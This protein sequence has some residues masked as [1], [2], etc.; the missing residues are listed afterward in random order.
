VQK[1]NDTLAK[2]ERKCRVIIPMLI[3]LLM[4]NLVS[5]QESVCTLQYAAYSGETVADVPNSAGSLFLGMDGSAVD[6]L[7]EA[8]ILDAAI[9][10]FAP[11]G[12]WF[13]AL[14]NPAGADSTYWGTGDARFLDPNPGTPSVFD[15]LLHT[16]FSETGIDSV[17][18]SWDGGC[19]DPPGVTTISMTQCDSTRLWVPDM[20]EETS[21]GFE[22]GSSP[23]WDD[24]LICLRVG[25]TD[26]LVAS[27]TVFLEGAYSGGQM[28]VGTF[29]SNVP[30]SQPYDSS[31]YDATVLDFDSTITVTELPDGSV[32]WMLVSLRTGPGYAAEVSGSE[33]AVIVLQDGRLVEPNGSRLRFPGIVTSGYY[34]VARHRNHISVMSSDTVDTGDGLGSWDFTSA[35]SQAY[36]LGPDAMR[37]LGSGHFGMF[38]GDAS[39]DGQI[40]APDF[41]LWLAATKAIATGYRSTDFDFNTQVTVT[42]FNLWLR[43]TKAVAASQVPDP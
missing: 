10:P 24:D 1:I 34:L 36:T 21:T 38:G 6:A 18:L 19:F 27:V 12:G 23:V 16:R 43:N 41:N 31:L 32:D 4:P 2:P 9:P 3:A 5:A 30:L 40:S 39:I 8:D 37:D 7:T 28:P 22:R 25:T 13:V 15:V 42:D 20:V 26:D 29:V 11:P 14:D 33:H 17:R 35:M